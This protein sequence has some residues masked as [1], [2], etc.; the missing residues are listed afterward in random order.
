[1]TAADSDSLAEGTAAGKSGMAF[2]ET[3]CG[4]FRAFRANRRLHYHFQSA[5]I[6]ALLLAI[7][8]A[9]FWPSYLDA[10]KV[11]GSLA[12]AVLVAKFCF[13]PAVV[14][15]IP[16]KTLDTEFTTPALTRMS[17]TFPRLYIA[18]T[19]TAIKLN[20]LKIVGNVSQLPTGYY[21]AYGRPEIGVYADEFIP[22]LAYAY[23][24]SLDFFHVM[25]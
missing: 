9:F 15:Y 17:V 14:V 3:L 22:K 24:T 13:Q 16:E 7:V 2:F 10:S 8:I 11:L 12:L 25:L 1:M 19:G 23:L 5:A 20:Y 4:E 21:D 18:Y 6:L